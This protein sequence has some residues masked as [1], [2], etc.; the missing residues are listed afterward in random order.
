MVDLM[1]MCADKSV[2]VARHLDAL[3]DSFTLPQYLIDMY[4]YDAPY[5]ILISYNYSLFSCHQ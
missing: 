2:L 3:N 4:Q 1:Y 5:H